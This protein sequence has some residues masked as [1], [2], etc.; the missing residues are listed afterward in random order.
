INHHK[1]YDE[2][3]L[4]SKPMLYPGHYTITMEF[5]GKISRQ[6]NGIYPCFFE[7]KGTSKKL[8]ATQFESHHAREVFPCIDEPEAKAIFE[9]TLTSPA[10]ETVLSNTPVASQKTVRGQT[11][12]RFEPTPH[13]STYLLAFILGELDY[14]EAKTKDGVVIRAYATPDNVGFTDFAL[15]T[16]IK[17]LEFY[18]DYFGIAYPLPKC[19]IIALP[20]FAAGAME[21]WGC[22]TFRE[23]AMLVDPKNTS[24]GTKQYVALVVAHE[25][26]HQWFGNLVTMRWWTDLWLNEGFAS[27]MEYLAVDHIFPDWQVWTQFIV[28]E[29]QQ[30]LKLDALEHTHPI[31]V[32][33]HHPDEIRT[34]FDAI[35]YSKGASVIHMLHE[36][37]GPEAFRDGLRHYL[38]THKYGNT[39]TKDLWASLEEISG[40]PVHQF[41]NAWTS[42]SGFP[43]LKAAIDGNSVTL[44]QC[45]F[46]TNPLHS[47]TPAQLWPLPLL[48]GQAGPETLTTATQQYTSA[49]A[50][51]LKL[52]QG[53]SGFYRVVYNTSHLQHLGERISQGQAEPLD[54]LGIL[55]DLFESAKA[56]YSDT[57]DALHFLAHFKS[58]N[59]YAV[60][61]SMTTAIGSLRLIMDDE[62]LREQ[63]KPYLRGLVTD[64][65]A[66][67]G[68]DKDET[69]SHFDRLLRPLILGLAASADEPTIVKKCQ[70]LFAFIHDADEVS[71]DLRS[72][73]GQQNVKRG[74]DIDPD[75]RGTVFGTVAR[76]GG[77]P[78]FEKLLK[79][80][81]NSSLSEERV[82]LAAALTGFQQ[83]E[84]IDRS[85]KLI[86]SDTVRLQDV[87]YWIAYSFL[88]RH[89]R[90]QTWVWL[91]EHWLW[92]HQN[93]GTDLSFYRMPIYAARVFSDPSFIPEYEEFFS[94]KMVPALD[95]SYKQGHEML[96]WQSAWKK[97]AFGEVK[98]FFSQYKQD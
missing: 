98:T 23:Q 18:N 22:I 57:A 88:N 29:Q 28:D 68:W 78:E 61:D 11:I 97:R 34:I 85:L 96:L 95:R 9:L 48:S 36:Y 49:N 64:Q 3:R 81:N 24:L 60:W 17:C 79:L 70:D 83:P 55:N 35:S 91:K 4:H 59:N 2:V 27:W 71:P 6:M 40:K 42:Q 80:H 89:A 15:E 1:K 52:N 46:F 51:H 32:A 30:A 63:M 77:K 90:K 10:K 86:T 93:L 21:N 47:S 20:D 66:R 62:D 82:T 13:M 92:L 26:T 7:H 25:L 41:M 53:Q 44:E 33:V 38:A 75:L 73:A 39:E 56:G 94:S 12:T 69:D 67:L 5:T 54:R 16:A 58:E 50:T 84:L 76:L 43:L 72:A 87:A 74:L 19:D 45:R 37:L 14:K 65:L 31:E 8:I